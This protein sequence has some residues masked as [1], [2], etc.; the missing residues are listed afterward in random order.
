MN[1][2]SVHLYFTDGSHYIYTVNAQ[3]E[4]SALYA[5]KEAHKSAQPKHKASINGSVTKALDE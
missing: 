1:Q 3:S 5:A 4:V 2:Y